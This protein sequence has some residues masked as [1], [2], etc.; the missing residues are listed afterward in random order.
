MQR[1]KMIG[2]YGKSTVISLP[3]CLYH[4]VFPSA[5]SEHKLRTILGRGQVG[6]GDK[7]Q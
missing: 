7:L 5:V 6:E 2:L 1:N 4:F 3:K